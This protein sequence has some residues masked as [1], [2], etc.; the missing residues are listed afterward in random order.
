L[1]AISEPFYQFL[2]QLKPPHL[3]GRPAYL[4]P[5]GAHSVDEETG[6]SDDALNFELEALWN[7][8]D[9]VDTIFLVRLVLV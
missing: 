3:L 6:E 1:R 2:L 8:P 4:V 9:K 7:S 5:G